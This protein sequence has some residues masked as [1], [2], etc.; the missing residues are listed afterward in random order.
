MSSVFGGRPAG[1]GGGGEDR[2]A[3]D[4]AARSS[5]TIGED[6]DDDGDGGGG[7]GSDD[8]GE[9]DASSAM[10]ESTWQLVDAPVAATASPRCPAG[11][12]P[13]S[14]PRRPPRTERGRAPS[15]F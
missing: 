6:D 11:A 10:A 1:G 13:P 8:D 5:G 2:V 14:C 4:G 9:D 12:E 3:P 15:V 7:G